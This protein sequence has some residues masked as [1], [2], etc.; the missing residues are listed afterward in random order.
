MTP[1]EKIQKKIELILLNHKDEMCEVERKLETNKDFS[2]QF[3]LCGRADALE[4]SI[5][6]LED[7]LR[8]P[9]LDK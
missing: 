4:K 7:L 3:E 1:F 2:C 5:N 8:N 6:A 9:Y